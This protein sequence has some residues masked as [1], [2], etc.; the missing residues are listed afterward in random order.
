MPKAEPDES[1]NFEQGEV[2]YHNPIAK[3]WTSLLNIS[4]LVLP[5]YY[6]LDTLF[7]VHDK[8]PDPEFTNYFE[9]TLI[10]VDVY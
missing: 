3:D 9:T 7:Y 1:V 8:V 2:I 5:I 10:D 4:S 6:F